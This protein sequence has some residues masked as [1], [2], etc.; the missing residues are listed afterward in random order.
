MIICNKCMSNSRYNKGICNSLIRCSM[1]TINFKVSSIIDQL[2]SRIFNFSMVQGKNNMK[3]RK[4]VIKAQVIT[5]RMAVSNKIFS[6]P[7]LALYN[8]NP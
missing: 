2:Q 7:C 4:L 5:I 1:I 6:D 3:N 8:E